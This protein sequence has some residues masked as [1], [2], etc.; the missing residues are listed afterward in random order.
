MDFHF[1]KGFYVISLFYFT[2]IQTKNVLLTNNPCQ[3]AHLILIKF[4]LQNLNVKMDLHNIR[5]TI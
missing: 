2:N 5:C 3:K 4:K 1:I